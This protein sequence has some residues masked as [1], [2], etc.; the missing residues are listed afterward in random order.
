MKFVGK[1]PST[2]FITTYGY[3]T[4]GRLQSTS[5]SVSGDVQPTNTVTLTYGTNAAQ[6]NN[7]RLYTMNNTT[8]S[9]TYSYNT[10]G[11]LTGVS[12]VIGG[13]TYNLGYGYNL[14]GQM[15][16]LTYPSGRVVEQQYDTAGRLSQIFNGATTYASGYNYNPSGA[17]TGFNYG[18]SVHATFGY[19]SRLQLE[20]LGYTNAG[21][22]LFSLTYD[23]HLGVD[24][25]GQIRK[26]TDNVDSG[27]TKNYTYDELG[28]LKTAVTNGSAAYPQ[29]GLQWSYDRYGNR[30]NQA[31]T[32]GGGPN[33]PLHV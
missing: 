6:N 32:A 25:N 16:S 13:V 19:N 4:L 18:N 24:N 26:I 27:G 5:Y 9:E 3:D 11:Q 2:P 28:R 31:V 33:V 20:T 21:T 30:T 12:K 22:S 8:A 29:W 10:L 14:A 1:E 23:Y 15:T 7:G 17:V